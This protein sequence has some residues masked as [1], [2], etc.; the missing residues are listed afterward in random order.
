MNDSGNRLSRRFRLV[1]RKA[2]DW[3]AA[4]VSPASMVLLISF[5]VGILSGLSA[6]ALKW[7]INVLGHYFKAGLNPYGP[8]LHLLCYPLAGILLVSV[9]Q[10][11]VLKKDYSRSTYMLSLAIASGR[12]RMTK[13]SIL[14]SVLT[15]G[16]T[17]GFGCTAG[18]EGPVAYSGA[19]IGSNVGRWLGLSDQW[20]RIL[21]GIGAGAGIAGIFKSPT[22]GVLFT[23][24]VLQLPMQTIP[25]IGLFIACILSGTTAKVFSDFSFDMM[26]S[27][28]RGFDPSTLG[29]IALFG[30]FCGLYSMLYNR[31]KNCSGKFFLSVADPW[32]RNIMAGTALSLTL[33]IFPCLFGEGMGVLES[34]ING[35]GIDLFSYGPFAGR[36]LSVGVVLL[37][38]A[39]ALLLKGPLVAAAYYGGGVA[40]DFMPTLFAGCFAGYFFSMCCNV[41]FGVGLPSWY[42]CL[43]GMGAVMAGSLHAPLMA[44]FISAEIT[45]S[46]QFMPAYVVAVSVSY[47]TVKLLTPRAWNVETGHDDVLSLRELSATP[48]LWR[49]ARRRRLG[50][51]GTGLDERIELEAGKEVSDADKSLPDR[52]GQ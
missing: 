24:E 18:S 23:L 29:W 36:D 32:H 3:Q 20:L 42:F 1:K 21:I 9:F 14:N 43:V 15:C 12:Y 4:H 45:D 27:S 41:F 39:A 22:G 19:A 28:V 52:N 37:C 25:V 8:N 44:L 6:V 50:M 16:L 10:R 31:L 13:S 40:G 49:A 5:I 17:I 35:Q 46:F 26:F 2:I 11:Y 47:I 48:A 34:A 38:C 33:F 7:F 51:K 30:I